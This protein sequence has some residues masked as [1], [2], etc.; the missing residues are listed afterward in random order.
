MSEGFSALRTI[1]ETEWVLRAPSD[2][3]VGWNTESRLTHSLSQSNCVALCQ[4]KPAAFST[5]IH[6]MLSARI[7][8]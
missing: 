2:L 8:L 4:Y 1:D 6:S 3:S 7:R 5:A